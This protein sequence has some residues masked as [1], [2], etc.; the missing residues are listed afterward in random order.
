MVSFDD[1]AQAIARNHQKDACVAKFVIKNMGNVE[2]FPLNAAQSRIKK[3]DNVKSDL[4][5]Y[6]DAEDI[7]PPPPPAAVTAPVAPAVAPTSASESPTIAVTVVVCAPALTNTRLDP[8]AIDMADRDILYAGAPRRTQHQMEIE[9]GQRLEAEVDAIYKS[10][11]GRSRGWTKVGLE[12]MIKPR[13]ASG[14][15]LHELDRAKKPFLWHI[16]S[17][18]KVMS[19]FLDFICVA[20][21]IRVAVWNEETRTVVLYPAADPLAVDAVVDD[22]ASVAIPLYH[23]DVTGRVRRNMTAGDVCAF[24]DSNN[25]SLLPPESV[26]HSLRGLKLEE[27]ESVGLRL[28]MSVVE[29]KKE[30]RVRAIAMYKTRARLAA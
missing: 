17:D 28:G 13:A 19:A 8:I 23:I 22:S 3:A 7:L 20:K 1:L 15:D 27:L 26:L 4:E 14:G 29:G 18:D 24:C 30:D 5:I 10:A 11:G 12:A 16:V 6:K 21:R 25:W 2:Y 9:E